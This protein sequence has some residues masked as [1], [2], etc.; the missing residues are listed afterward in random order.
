MMTT[1]SWLRRSGRVATLTLLGMAASCTSDKK[2]EQA[3]PDTRQASSGGSASAVT[4]TPGEAGLTAEGTV[5]GLATVKAIDPATRKVT[6]ATEDGAQAPFTVPPEVRNFDQ[7]HVGDRVNATVHEKLVVFVDRS[8][9][10]PSVAHVA[11]LARA[12]EGAKPGAIVAEAFEVVATVTSID[13]ANRRATLR[14]ADGQT[15]TIPVREDVDLTRYKVGD[16]VV[17]RISQH[18]ALLVE[19]K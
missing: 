9:R 4:Y 3:S 5:T 14:F 11:G 19:A 10:E 18:L 17:M 13:T 2:P 12:P 7:I 15:K 8:G 16:S 1:K 6:L